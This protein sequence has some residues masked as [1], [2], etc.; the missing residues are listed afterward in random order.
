MAYDE[1][2]AGRIRTLLIDEPSVTEKRMFGGLAFLVSGHLT[3][4]A[5]SKGELMTRTAASDTHHPYLARAEPM[6]MRGRELAGWLTLPAS[7]V[8]D[9]ESL[10]AVVA[11]AVAF[12]R[13][14]PAK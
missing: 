4:A 7:A 9:D 8:G 13:T 11:H 12:V 2:L 14:L 5:N 3:V 6:V 10:A 1:I